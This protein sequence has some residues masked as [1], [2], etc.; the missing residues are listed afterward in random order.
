MCL[1]AAEDREHQTSAWS[2]CFFYNPAVLGAGKQGFPA[3]GYS[4]PLVVL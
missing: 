4:V 3:L 1:Q 2:V